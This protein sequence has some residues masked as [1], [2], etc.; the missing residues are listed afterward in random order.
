[1]SERYISVTDDE[2]VYFLDTQSEDYR[3]LEDFEKKEFETAKKDNVDIKEYEDAIL[4]SAS[5]KY[6][7]WVYDYHIDCDIVLDLLNTNEELI[8]GYIES[9]DDLQK[10][11]KFLR[12]K[13]ESNSQDDYID[14]LEK[15]NERLKER[16]TELSSNDKI[17]FMNGQY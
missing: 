15:Q 10:E 7:E 13:I 9:I 3:T 12:C 17:V 16:I 4:T 6:W 8:K 2:Y 14:Y 1:M 11:N 5:D